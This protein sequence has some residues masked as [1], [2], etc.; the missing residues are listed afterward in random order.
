MHVDVSACVCVRKVEATK[1]T[2]YFFMPIE[3]RARFARIRCP[4]ELRKDLVNAGE[5][6][7]KHSDEAHY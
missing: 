5:Y 6:L 7:A 1:K 4:I 3:R 2:P